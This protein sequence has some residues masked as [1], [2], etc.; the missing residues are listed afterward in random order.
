MWSISKRPLKY[1][2]IKIEHARVLWRRPPD[3]LTCL[4]YINPNN[5]IE[6]KFIA[7]EIKEFKKPNMMYSVIHFLIFLNTS[8]SN[9]V[10]MRWE[11]IRCTI[12]IVNLIY[13][14]VQ[15]IFVGVFSGDVPVYVGF[16][17]HSDVPRS[18]IVCCTHCWFTRMIFSFN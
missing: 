14:H 18:Y 7:V 11:I 12:Y 9:C 15:S 10:S 13:I 17:N 5:Y 1:Q 2:V 3:R 16:F 6:V 8:M 4:L